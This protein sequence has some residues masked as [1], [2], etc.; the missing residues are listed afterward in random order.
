MSRMMSRLRVG[1]VGIGFIGAAHIDAIRRVPN[2]EVVALASSSSERAS[3]HA[4][5]LG[6]PRAYGDYRELIADRDIDVVH[7]CTP[8]ALHLPVNRAILEAG[9]ACYAEKPLAMNA[10]EARELVE[11]ARK[12]GAP[13]AVNFNHRGFPQVQIAP[14]APRV[15]V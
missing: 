6:I 1:V 8:N 7:N 15:S 2:V 12:T 9:K 13:A 10:A 14:T 3:R 4:D 5:E 11:I